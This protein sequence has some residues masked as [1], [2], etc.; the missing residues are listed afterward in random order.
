[1]ALPRYQNVGVEVAGGVRGI[2]FPSRGE[3]TRGLDTISNVLDRMS[4][5][6]FK[7][8]AVAATAEG[9]KYGAQNA[10][11]QEQ[12]RQAIETGTPLPPVGDSRTYFGKSAK[13]AYS[14][15]LTTQIQYAAK[16]DISKIKS[17][18][19]AGSIGTGSIVPRI[20]SVIKGYSGALADVD[21]ALGKKIEAQLAYE[22]NNAYLA[23]SKSAASKAA[24]ELKT[25]NV[26]NGFDLVNTVR[27][28]IAA[29]DTI[30]ADGKL[31]TIN[32]RIDIRAAQLRK[33]MEKLPAAAAKELESKFNTEISTQQKNYA[34][35]WVMAGA[36]HE[37]R[38]VRLRAIQ[39]VFSKKGIDPALDPNGSVY[40]VIKNMDPNEVATTIKASNEMLSIRRNEDKALFKKQDA[41]LFDNQTKAYEGF[42]YNIEA[43]R[44]GQ[45]AIPSLEEIKKSGLPI[46]GNREVNQLNLLKQ[47]NSLEFGEVKRDNGVY[48]DLYSR[49]SLPETDPNRLKS[50]EDITQAVATGR[51]R[52]SDAVV[53]YDVLRNSKTPEGRIEENDKKTFLRAA[54]DAL[55][56]RNPVTGLSQG[57]DA[58]LAFEQE[59][60]AEYARRKGLGE[61]PLDLLNPNDRN[62][63]WSG[64]ARHQ[65]TAME[66][67]NDRVKSLKPPAPPPPPTQ[68]EPPPPDKGPRKPGESLMDYERRRGQ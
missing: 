5:S 44:R 43:A 2:D 24:A 3:S 29:G 1:M 16:A 51:I 58:Y 21:P 17:D 41:E 7:E 49:A 48:Q 12:L 60:N 53:L 13:N 9:E 46:S 8:A 22:G 54:R 57:A 36:E 28:D 37:E 31:V 23:A 11:T 52:S 39:D 63:L 56:S 15:V 61:K 4:E 32:D 45:G 25:Q 33:I 30:G 40:R 47:I 14:E 19:E 67:L 18:A 34:F 50:S 55:T 35:S 38:E 68:T 64:V 62:S 27:D 20:N 66:L 42:V 26:I 10:P 59:F 65:K 6:F